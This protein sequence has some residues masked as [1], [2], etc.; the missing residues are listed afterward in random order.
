MSNKYSS[1]LKQSVPQTQPLHSGQVKNAAGGWGTQI[2]AW[3]QLERFL[4]LGTTGG[5]YYFNERTLTT[6]NLQVIEGL[7]KS[8]E[9]PKVVERVLEVDLQGRAPKKAAAHY[10]LALC[11]KHGN[12]ETRAAAYLALPKVCRTA[13]HLFD[14]LSCLGS[15]KKGWGRGLK[16]AVQNWYLQRHENNLA[17]QVVKY[18]SRSGFTH[19]DVL[20]LAHP[21][22]SVQEGHRKS[23][24]N[25]AVKGGQECSHPLIQDFLQLQQCGDAPDKAIEILQRTGLPWESL[26]TELHGNPQIWEAL[27]HTMPPQALIRNLNRLSALGLTGPNTQT[28]KAIMA[29]LTDKQ[30]LINSRI[31][32]L[33]LMV[34]GHVYASGRGIKGNLTWQP[35]DGIMMALEDATMLAYK[36]LPQV[37][38]PTF[39]GIDVSGS[40]HTRARDFPGLSLH[41]ISACMA[42]AHAEMN[43]QTQ[44]VVFSTSYQPFRV[45]NRSLSDIQQDL[46]RMSGG[47]DLGQVIYAAVNSGKT[48]GVYPKLVIIYT[49]NE[50][51]AGHRHCD[52]L[53][54]D[55]LTLVPDARLIVFSMV[56]NKIAA[57]DY[58]PGVLNAA[59]FDTSMPQI[60]A[61]WGGLQTGG[62]E[63]SE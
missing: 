5:S 4:I 2:S 45:G 6:D 60:V 33:S 29:K 16:R 7:I 27:L 23:I 14:F 52:Q 24:L 31:H 51:W 28:S 47:T 13:S 32:P 11:I 53:W 3:D 25:W 61:S 40:M 58:L 50:T 56:A 35:N 62:D 57:F 36:S 49:D 8:Q 43:P 26:P 55:Y 17:L 12:L 20:R 21:P 48:T 39:V 10:I 18:R 42:R 63:S 37:D 54:K 30:Y 22:V 46:S 9:G 38:T 59:G 41:Q 34:A 15:V 19:K 44:F 1:I